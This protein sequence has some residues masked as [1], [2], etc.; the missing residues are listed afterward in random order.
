MIKTPRAARK[1]IGGLLAAVLLLLALPLATASGIAAPAQAPGS[2][3]VLD[4][5]EGFAAAPTFSGFIHTPTNATILLLEVP[6]SAY[7]EMKR[8]LSPE[9]LTG[10]GMSQV[11]SRA[12]EREGEHVYVTAE[13]AT[14]AGPFAKFILL[15]REGQLTALVSASVPKSTIESGAISAEAIERTLASARV[16]PDAGEKPYALGY[17]GPFRDTGAF[18]G[19]SHFYA[20][21]D[22]PG[23]EREA[24]GMP[25]SL[26]VASSLDGTQVEDLEAMGRAGIKE[27]AG[28][29]EPEEVQSQRLEIAGLEAVENVVPPSGSGEPADAGVY[30]VVLRASQGGYYRIVGKAPA[31]EWPALLPEF[32]KIAQS[33][34]PRT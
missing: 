15:F 13:Q 31:P 20:I 7:S 12:L 3:L 22:P 2:R 4:V 19:Q 16:A 9:T 28:G 1:P 6:A 33:F 17:T 29:Q 30:Q 14:P 27:L 11:E 5:P 18:I 24:S 23:K 25:P 10:Q 21:V 34:T 32:R 26:I 8:G